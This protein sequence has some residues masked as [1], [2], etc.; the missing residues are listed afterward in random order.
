MWALNLPILFALSIGSKRIDP[1][2]VSKKLSPLW[3]FCTEKNSDIQGICPFIKIVAIYELVREIEK[4]RWTIFFS[5]F[6]TFCD[7]L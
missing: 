2:Q 7:P 6:L 1:E 3:L 5:E 4:A